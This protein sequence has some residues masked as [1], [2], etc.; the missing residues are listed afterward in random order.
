VADKLEEIETQWRDAIDDCLEGKITRTKLEEIRDLACADYLRFKPSGTALEFHKEFYYR[1]HNTCES[2]I[3]NITG[4]PVEDDDLL[5][6]N[7]CLSLQSPADPQGYDGYKKIIAW[8][9]EKLPADSYNDPDAAMK[10]GSGIIDFRREYAC[11]QWLA[12][13]DKIPSID[14]NHPMWVRKQVPLNENVPKRMWDS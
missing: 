3:F 8:A 10:E 6:L 14:M 11:R 2:H 13:Q 12:K 5:R 9:S 1:W 7:I 4:Y